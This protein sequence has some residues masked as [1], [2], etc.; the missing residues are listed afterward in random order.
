MKVLYKAVVAESTLGDPEAQEQAEGA[1]MVAAS[2]FISAHAI[3]RYRQ[4]VDPTATTRQ[5]VQSIRALLASGNARSRPRKWTRVPVRAGF[6]YLYSS[7]PAD[8]CLVLKGGAVVTV[9]SRAAC[10]EWPEPP[11]P[12]GAR[13]RPYRRPSAG[14]DF[15]DVA[16]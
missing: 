13:P 16:S 15:S 1:V 12:Q 6:R 3:E 14:T 11:I 10:T 7:N 4:R 2:P 8:V 9:F 5:A